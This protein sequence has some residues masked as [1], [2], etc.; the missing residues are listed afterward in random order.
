MSDDCL[1]IQKVLPGDH[2]DWCKPG[3]S[4]KMDR[5]ILMLE[6]THNLLYSWVGSASSWAAVQREQ[7]QPY[8]GRRKGR[9]MR[10]GVKRVRYS[11]QEGKVNKFQKRD[12]LLATFSDN[13]VSSYL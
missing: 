8:G 2:T 12:N 9:R 6:T 10:I 13:N 11:G 7:D 3:T 4:S 1:Q 5:F